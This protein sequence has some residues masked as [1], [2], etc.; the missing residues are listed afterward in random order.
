MTESTN[1]VQSPR[2]VS[3]ASPSSGA[4]TKKSA[5]APR[6][7]TVGSG[8]SLQR[9][10]AGI[11]AQHVVYEDNVIET[12]R[13]ELTK[14]DGVLVWVNPIHEGRNRVDLD[15]LLRDV[16]KS[17]T[18]VSAHPDVILKMGTKEVLYRTRTM[19]WGVRY[20]P[21]SNARR[22]EH[23]ITRSARSRSARDQTQ[24]R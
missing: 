17:G 22:N 19:S 5:G 16:A 9:S 3:A 24:S 12:A 23:R 11:D 7:K 21:L 10:K 18:G 20:G 2:R 1:R 13:T 14:V 8:R 15:A 6:Q 4:A